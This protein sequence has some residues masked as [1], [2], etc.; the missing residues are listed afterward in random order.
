MLNAGY[1]R[2]ADLWHVAT[3]LYVTPEPGEISFITLD[4][5]QRNV[6]MALGFPGLKRLTQGRFE[7]TGHPPPA[8][9]RLTTPWGFV[10]DRH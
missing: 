1:L 5:R 3:A 9:I 8:P 2:G 4:R 10:M 7:P 6:A